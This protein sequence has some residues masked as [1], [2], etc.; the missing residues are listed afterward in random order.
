[1]PPFLGT[2]DYSE[3]GR[4]AMA[5]KPLQ[6]K[7]IVLGVTG[8]IACYKAADLAS[9]LAQA[10]A[11]VDTILTQSAT[12]FLTPLT[13]Q[14]VTGRRAYTD[15]ELWGSEAHV[16]HVGLGHQADLLVIAPLTANTLA[17]LAHG[18]ADD[19]LSVTAL[20]ATCPLLLAPAMDAG[21]FTHPA[22]QANLRILQERGARVVGPEEG[23]LASGMVAKGRMSEPQTLLAEIRYLLRRQGPL[24][25]YQVVVTA[26]GTREAVDPVRYLTN[27]SSGKQGYAVAQAALDA[28]ADVTLITTV[29]SLPLPAG[30]TRVPVTSAVEMAQAV[31]DACAGAHMLVMAAAVADFRPAN[32][33]EQK[34][35]KEKG[36]PTLELAPNPD[37]LLEVAKQRATTGKPDVVVGFAAE[38]EKL[39]ENAQAKLARKG[40]T[41]IV[42]NDV[43]AVDAGFAVDTNRITLIDHTGQQETLPLM[44]KAEVAEKVIEAATRFLHQA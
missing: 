9:K 4:N 39:L 42:A 32:Q 17:K 34:I 13:F 6:N 20:A 16:L 21:M 12:H 36:T 3:M 14:S 8:S 25:G 29:D 33:A 31:L 44:S 28:G 7:R 22:T 5:Q 26:G 40:L 10:G 43:S 37:I 35:K 1:M 18:L 27:H 41:L 15:A 19:L 2:A 24:Q 30:A 23:H 11:Q 38:T